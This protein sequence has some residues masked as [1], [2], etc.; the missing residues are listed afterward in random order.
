MELHLKI[1][2]IILMGISFMHVGFPVYFKWKS[3]LK[4]LNLINRQMMQT[5]TFFIAL[6]VGMIGFLC[7][8]KGS[9]LVTEPLGHFLAK[10]LMIFWLIR[11]FFQFFVY[12]P[13][14][15]W[16]KAF[17]TAMHILFSLFWG[18][19]TWVFYMVGWQGGL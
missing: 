2:G 1:I 9:A 6:S 14:L 18:Y 10:G 3:E 15:W 5:H 12:S 11:M 7:Y 16:G 19:F 13:K 17:E 4:S 8:F